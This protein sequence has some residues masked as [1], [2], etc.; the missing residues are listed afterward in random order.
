MYVSDPVTPSIQVLIPVQSNNV[1]HV[2]DGTEAYHTFSGFLLLSPC[3]INSGAQL[4]YKH[5]RL[6]ST[7]TYIRSHFVESLLPADETSQ[8]KNLPFLG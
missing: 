3:A 4:Q 5:S 6:R 7:Y 1:L 2:T 8:K